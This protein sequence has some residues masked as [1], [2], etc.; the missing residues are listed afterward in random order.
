MT[1][2]LLKA[3]PPG[4]HLARRRCRSVAVRRRGRRAA[5][6]DR[7]GRAAVI[8]LD[9]IF[10]Q[11]QDSLIIA[12]AHRI[13]HG[14]MPECPTNARDFFMFTPDDRRAAALIVDLVSSR[15]PKKFGI[16]PADIQVLAR[17]IAAGGVTG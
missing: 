10:R 5:R 6:R 13:N 12:N 8:R 17:C 4:A 9:V 11:A 15:I 1:N 3:L 2:H 7:F 14:K 16:K